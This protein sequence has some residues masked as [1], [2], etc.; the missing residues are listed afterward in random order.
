MQIQRIQSVYIFLSIVAMAIFLVVPYGQAELL[1]ETPSVFEPL[2]TM[3]EYGIL[4][5]T[6]A[7]VILL[8]VDLFLYRNMPLQRTVLVVS[9]MITLATAATVC[10]TLLGVART[11]GMDAHFSVWDILLPAAAL[12][13][14][15]GIKGIM[16]DIKLLNSY[17]RLR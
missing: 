10:F 11:E 3:S 7:T 14:I 15:L 17:N 1:T 2:Y 13:E 8:L 5:P 6:G 4:I 9:L 12:F 16:H